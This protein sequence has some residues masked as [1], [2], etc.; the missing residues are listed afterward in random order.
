MWYKNTNYFSKIKLKYME[1]ERFYRAAYHG[2]KDFNQKQIETA[3][4]TGFGAAA[5]DFMERGID[6][7]EQLI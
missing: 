5:D 3:N 7:N 1:R 6:L 2:S 4:A